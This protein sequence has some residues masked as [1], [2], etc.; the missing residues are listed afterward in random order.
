MQ[1]GT[2]NRHGFTI[3]ELMVIIIVVGIL[4][5]ITVVSYGAWRQQINRDATTSDLKGVAGALENSRNFSETG[6]PVYPVNTTFN[7]GAAGNLFTSSENVRLTYRSGTS[8]TY[9]IEGTPV[10]G[11]SFRL[12]ITNTMDTPRE[13]SCP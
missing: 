7:S 9:C 11:T 8:T 12:Y 6:Y 1:M 5:G 2:K 4:V 3:V 13:G 10:S